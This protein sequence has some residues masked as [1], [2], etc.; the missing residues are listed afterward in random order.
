MVQ[1]FE[2]AH[3]VQFTDDAFVEAARR[4]ADLWSWPLAGQITHW[5]KIGQAI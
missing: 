4:E 1:G 3:S 5:A 2:M